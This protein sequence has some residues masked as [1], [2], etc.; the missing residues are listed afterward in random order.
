MVIVVVV[1]VVVLSDLCDKNT[2]R[3]PRRTSQFLSHSLSVSC[4]R[5]RRRLCAVTKDSE[6]KTIILTETYRKDKTEKNE[7]KNQIYVF[8]TSLNF[9]NPHA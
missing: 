1:I 3:E 9:N 6:I 4:K 7:K 2:L 5:R 8:V